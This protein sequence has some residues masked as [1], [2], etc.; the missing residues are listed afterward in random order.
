MTELE[1]PI[2]VILEGPDC[3]GKTTLAGK[4]PGVRIHHGPLLNLDGHEFFYKMIHSLNNYDIIDRC[5]IS[6]FIY[7]KQYR[8]ETR[9]DP[10][11]CRMF[12]RVA[13]SRGFVILRCLT[14]LETVLNTFLD[15]DEYLDN[16]DILA[17]IYNKYKLMHTGCITI[18]FNYKF[19]SLKTV[20]RIIKEVSPDIN[21]G[22]GIGHQVKSISN[23][24]IAPEFGINYNDES[25]EYAI[26]KYF[27]DRGISEFYLY[28]VK[29]EHLHLVNL[30]DYKSVYV[31]EHSSSISL[32]NQLRDI[33]H[34]FIPGDHYASNFS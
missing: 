21:T 22:P 5:W 13:Y 23:L 34:T 7:G 1:R 6:E 29:P 19:Q 16:T 24:V 32:L 28:W 26:T 33:P 10:I 3:C 17:K 11:H 20:L 2:R 15:R 4:L 27:Y 25:Y 31:P 12:N 14:D 8:G 9:I 30:S 18:N